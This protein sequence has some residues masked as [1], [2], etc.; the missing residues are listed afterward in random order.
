MEGGA[1]PPARGLASTPAHWHAAQAGPRRKGSEGGDDVSE[2]RLQQEL[3]RKLRGRGG[4][5]QA[6]HLSLT[7]LFPG[8]GE[9]K[10]AVPAAAVS[11]PMVGQV[12]AAKDGGKQESGCQFRRMSYRSGRLAIPAPVRASSA[13]WPGG[14]QRCP[15][16]T[17]ALEAADFSRGRFCTFLGREGSSSPGAAV[18]P[19]FFAVRTVGRRNREN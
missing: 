18:F 12:R 8:A 15:P 17:S 11:G 1:T 4:S 10:A 13:P 2:R 19:F 14:L 5:E 6:R 9:G 7:G 16:P 3:Q